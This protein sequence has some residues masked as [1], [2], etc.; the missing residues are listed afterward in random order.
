MR[1][2]RQRRPTAHCCPS[3]ARPGRVPARSPTSSASRT[4]R[5]SC[6]RRPSRPVSVGELLIPL[7]SPTA[8]SED[9][10]RGTGG[11]YLIPSLRCCS[12]PA[13][14]TRDGDTATTV[15]TGIPRA[16]PLS[17]GQAVESV[18]AAGAVLGEGHGAH[19]C[20]K[21]LCWPSRN[22]SQLLLCARAWPEHSTLIS[23]FLKVVLSLTE[24]MGRLVGF[25]SECLSRGELSP[26]PSRS[27]P[28][29]VRSLLGRR[30][31]D[32]GQ[33]EATQPLLV[34]LQHCQLQA[35]LGGDSLL[36][37]LLPP[38]PARSCCPWLLP[39]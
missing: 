25:S 34:V 20:P 24:A 29:L 35:L 38:P 4:P 10:S 8:G 15:R 14:G 16:A 21:P 18:Q 17:A 12:R 2:R 11:G 23:S 33:E 7:V 1:R 30:G 9:S 32:T 39:G 6:D 19:P 5:R 37:P 3:P 27:S 28:G 36:L 13:P 26:C 22:R 31:Q